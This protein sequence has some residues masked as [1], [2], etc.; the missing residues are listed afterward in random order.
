MTQGAV[1]QQVNKLEQWLER[2]LFVRRRLRAGADARGAS[3]LR[4]VA[5]ESFQALESTL[6]QLTQARPIARRWRCPA[7]PS[8]AMVWLTP[9]AW[10]TSSASTRT[11]ACACM[12]SSTRAGPFADAAP[13]AS[14]P[15]C[16]STP[17]TIPD[18][19]ATPFL[20][21]WLLPVASPAYLAAHPALRSPDG[22]ARHDRCCTT[23]A[24]GKA[25]ATA[26]NGRIGCGT[27]A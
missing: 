8:F 16:A 18:L 1:S 23:P 17:A 24:R 7:H 9:R 13:K 25:P 4:G 3:A 11:S 2:P 12:A 21:E 5:R 10:A 20:D 14:T 26:T 22:P 6:A 19:R 15:P 27:R